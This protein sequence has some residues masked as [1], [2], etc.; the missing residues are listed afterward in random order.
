M[1]L[2]CR[3]LVKKMHDLKFVPINK[4]NYPWSQ[5]LFSTLIFH[6]LFPLLFLPTF[7][8]LSP[9]SLSVSFFF[10]SY[11]VFT[12]ACFSFFPVPFLTYMQL[13]SYLYT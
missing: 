5:L 4:S 2:I 11:K 6:I 1:H 3:S 8:F 9:S 12:Y 7:Y 10:L 13:L